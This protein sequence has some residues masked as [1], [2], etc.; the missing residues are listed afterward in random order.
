MRPQNN[1]MHLNY[2]RM[3]PLTFDDL[4]KVVGP[5]L[6]SKI[7]IFGRRQVLLSAFTTNLH[8]RIF[9][10]SSILVILQSCVTQAMISPNCLD[11]KSLN[12]VYL[13]SLG[14]CC[15]AFWCGKVGFI[16]LFRIGKKRVGGKACVIVRHKT[17]T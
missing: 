15:G 10:Y 2:F 14:Y 3:L 16:Q 7:I 8:S 9:S 12:S 4:L 11:H 17:R 6:R 1:E 13:R 5:S